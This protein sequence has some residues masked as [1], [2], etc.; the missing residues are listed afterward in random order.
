MNKIRRDKILVI[1]LV[2]MGVA[3]IF[4]LAKSYWIGWQMSWIDVW[5]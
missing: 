4:R 2:V 1:V 5:P 3:L